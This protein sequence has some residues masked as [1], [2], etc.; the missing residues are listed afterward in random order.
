MLEKNQAKGVMIR[1]EGKSAAEMNCEHSISTDSENKKEH[2]KFR[3]S[4]KAMK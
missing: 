4:W 1:I 2:C 3:F